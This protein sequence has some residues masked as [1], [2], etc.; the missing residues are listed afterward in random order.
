MSRFPL[1]EDDAPF[2]LFTNEGT[3]LSRDAL[4]AEG[5]RLLGA[6]LPPAGPARLRVAL[7]LPTSSRL[8][9][10]LAHLVFD[11]EDVLVTVLD[12]RQ[13]PDELADKVRD[14]QPHLV[15]GE[16]PGLSDPQTGSLVP[17]CPLPAYRRQA[18]EAASPESSRLVVY[19]SGTTG[20]EKGVLLS[21][22]SIL[23]NV[24][25][26]R[27][28]HDL[29]PSDVALCLVSLSHINGL[30]VTFFAPWYTGGKVVFLQDA[31]DPASFLA[32]VESRRITWFAGVP[33]HFKMMNS[34][35]IDASRHDFSSLRF[36]R[37]SS[38]ALPVETKRRFEANTGLEILPTMGMTE[39]G[40]Q[41]FANLSRRDELDGSVGRPVGFEARVAGPDG[42]PLAP[43]EEGQ[44]QV[45]GAG[46]MDGYFGAPA[47]SSRAI[48]AE[49]WLSTG[50]TGRMDAEGY[51]WVT[52][53]QKEIFIFNGENVSLALVERYGF[54]VPG[55]CDVVAV[56][57][58][59]RL[60]GEGAHVLYSVETG[61]SVAPDALREA[62]AP[63]L[64]HP[65]ALLAVEPAAG[66]EI[67]RTPSGKVVR[68]KLARA[69]EARTRPEVAS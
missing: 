65:S 27:R 10:L 11:R 24:E 60:F 19:T 25:C 8:A 47:D 29:A 55:V 54:T 51:F 61:A 18:P 5:R 13:H 39:C 34:V 3:W 66:V 33:F 23:H 1:V 69:L 46:L 49:G 4:R 17:G 2:C 67:P 26:L 37:Q 41:V 31:F 14:F 42:R 7:C 30:A 57:R 32:T 53:R 50:D 6:S 9:A 20:R 59:H 21:P 58:P 64:P 68:W 44:F 28:T 45:R 38:A 40:G 52:G 36:C 22:R 48:D 12:H 63:H 56:A 35:R 16:H 43:G 15:V 62:I